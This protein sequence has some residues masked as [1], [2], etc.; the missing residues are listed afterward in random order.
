MAGCWR[1]SGVQQG[2]R[3][4]PQLAKEWGT[5]AA[6]CSSALEYRVLMISVKYLEAEANKGACGPMKEQ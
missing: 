5:L 1:W 2:V 6:S 4:A 3:E